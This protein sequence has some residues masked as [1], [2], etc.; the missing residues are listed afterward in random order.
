MYVKYKR[1][2]R[3]PAVYLNRERHGYTN[4]YIHIHTSGE[5]PKMFIYQCI[6]SEPKLC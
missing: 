1:R 4:V 6:I 2:Y 5:V 3:S